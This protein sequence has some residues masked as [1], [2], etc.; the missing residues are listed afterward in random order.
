MSD[1]PLENHTPN[2]NE[3]I[4]QYPETSGQEPLN[5]TPGP[6]PVQPQPQAPIPY[7]PITPMPDYPIYPVIAWTKV[8]E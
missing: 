3:K 4:R 6:L 2:T 8:N 7:T 5:Q 1:N